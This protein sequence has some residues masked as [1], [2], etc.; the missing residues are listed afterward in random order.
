MWGKEMSSFFT[1][2]SPMSGTHYISSGNV[3]WMGELMYKVFTT[4][5]KYLW[6]CKQRLTH[7]CATETFSSFLKFIHDHLAFL[8]NTD[9]LVCRIFLSLGLSGVSSWLASHYIFWGRNTTEKMY[10]FSVSYQKICSI[11][12]IWP[13]SSC[14]VTTFFL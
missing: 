7:T 11:D 8:K 14:K 3:C 13:F 1:L 6:P 4:C 9:Q 12:G 5:D 10:F 2:V